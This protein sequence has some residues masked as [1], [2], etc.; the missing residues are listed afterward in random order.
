MPTARVTLVTIFESFTER[1][2]RCMKSA[3][4]LLAFLL[5]TPAVIAQTPYIETFEVR[6]HNLD[7]VVTD[8][9]GTPVRGLTK[10]DFVVVENGANQ[11]VTN[12][13]IYDSQ[14][15]VVESTP[16]S[17]PNDAS[18]EAPT[19]VV[20]APPPRRFVF[21]IDDLGLQK[22][23]RQ[24]L[25]KN[26]KSFVEQMREGDLAAVVRPTT[27]VKVVQEFT[28]DRA[29]LEKVLQ[30]VIDESGESFL[31]SK[32]EITNLRWRIKTAGTPGL[33]FIAKREY[34]DAAARRVEHRLG[35]VRALTSSLGGLPGKKVVILVAMGLSTK[36]GSEAWDL[37]EL[38]RMNVMADADFNAVVP[39]ELDV[40]QDREGGFNPIIHDLTKP[41]ADIARSA[42]ANGVTIYAL[43]PDV[44]LD[45]SVRGAAS[46]PPVA[47]RGGQSR[48]D[49][50]AELQPAFQ[51]DFIQNAAATLTSLTEKTGG[52]WF[53]GMS[54][55]DDAFRQVSDDVN[56]Y[57]SLA[58]RATGETDKAR[59]VTVKV[60]NRPELHVRTRSE[61]MEKSTD[62]EMT[63]LVVASL[64]YPRTVNELGIGVTPGKPQK[65]R[66][67]YTI[68]LDVVIPL[69][70]LTFLPIDGG[71]YAASFDMHYAAAGEQRD[72]GT[73]GKQEQRIELSPEQYAHVRDIAYRYKTAIQ[74]SPG[75]ARIAI[76]ILDAA[77]KLTG[78][79]TVEVIAQ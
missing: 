43:E 28:G 45:F 26:L 22:M 46:I 76:G 9:K 69:K 20:S 12:F 53:R 72:F 60:R 52:R 32:Q 16:Q 78:F 25:F 4:L 11:E 58:Y 61:V 19:S 40:A 41:I 30:T 39:D 17:A 54:S 49:P 5:L 36:P 62:R 18:A 37:A 8:K 68:P 42:A 56:F 44:P 10:D 71:K 79:R 23:A 64:L 48:A 67:L 6:L 3:A 75:R 2:S 77:T 14:S 55:I 27:Q 51:M 63:D 15:T 50:R 34:A 35:Q 7:V 13:A 38:L 70:N 21:F 65:D 1:G 24:R 73:G 47:T 66:G 29:A 74:V 33:R 57:Y 31:G 59:A